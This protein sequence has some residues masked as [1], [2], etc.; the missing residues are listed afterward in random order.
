MTYID[1][2]DGLIDDEL[3]EQ[4][5][6]ASVS[7][8]RRLVRYEGPQWLIEEVGDPITDPG[9][10]DDELRIPVR[11]ET[12][13]WQLVGWDYDRIIRTVDAYGEERDYGLVWRRPAA[14]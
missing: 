11:I 12:V 9:A 4:Y 8:L 10:I 13:E 6:G 3:T 7:L 1:D 5:D 2:V 14:A